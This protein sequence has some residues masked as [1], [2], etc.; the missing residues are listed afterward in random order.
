MTAGNASA[1]GALLKQYRM[2]AGLTQE[3]LAERA[4]LS[5][6]GLLYL[7][8]GTRRPYPDT[9]RRLEEA[10]ALSPEQ[11]DALA[12]AAR[13]AHSG[14]E[15]AAPAAPLILAPIPSA[16]TPL[17]GRVREVMEVTTL[18][19]EPEMRLVTL[20]GPG[21]I[22]KTRL[23]LAVATALA[24]DSGNEV[25]FA[26]LAA[27]T[28]PELVLPAITAALG[29]KV[30]TSELPME[31]VRVALRDR[32]LLLILDNFEQI[33]AAAPEIADLLAACPGITL[34]VTSRATL[35]LRGEHEFAV[36]PMHLPEA[37]HAATADALGEYEAI[38]LFVDRARAITPDFRL[39]EANARAVAEIC[40]RLDGLPLA[41]ELAAARIR[42]LTPIALLTRLAKSLTV[43]T[44]GARDLPARQQTL[45]D[46]IRWSYDLLNLDERAL[47]RR[48]AVFANG[49]TLEAI[50][51][52]CNSAGDLAIDLLDGLE[53]LLS[54]SLLY[55]GEGRD[56]DARFHMLQTIREFGI[57]QL[58][59]LGEAEMLRERHAVYF[60]AVA[61]EGSVELRGAR[62]DFWFGRLE[63][64]HD[65]LRAVLDWSLAQRPGELPLRLANALGLFWQ[66]HGYND[67][68]LRWLEASLAAGQ[69]APEALRV[70]ALNRISTLLMRQGEFARARAPLEASLAMGQSAGDL[71]LVARALRNLGILAYYQGDYATARAR[72]EAALGVYQAL[73][74]GGSTGSVLNNLGIIAF[75][76]ADYVQ[77]RELYER[78]L[79]Q[80]RVQGDQSAIANAL[81]NLALIAHLLGDYAS[82]RRL[83]EEGLALR[84]HAGEKQAIAASLTNLGFVCADAGDAGAR[85]MLR[86]GLALYRRVGDR[87]GATRAQLYLELARHYQGEGTVSD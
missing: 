39:T 32:R 14:N 7:E 72:S 15:P 13:S 40:Q 2:R 85:Q 56:G 64:E 66:H 38:R 57:E 41:I 25:A 47:L 70:D 22:G 76:E 6:R 31:D 60:L 35:R 29:I 19:R 59:A 79:A 46:T 73:G 9:L 28:D 8:H 67:E 20:T 4:E 55:R 27:L 78:S 49:C 10:L 42:T 24:E 21:G 84:R 87:L 82:A 52:V 50:E 18:L 44:G 71:W 86:E 83:H 53:S 33:V 74:D 3:E 48:L 80:V 58:D 69:G 34:L 77:A 65:N 37:H 26:P 30:G 62:Q 36:P 11:R 5:V 54:Q 12:A 45:R 17:V 81:N 75:R 23:A 51:A 63:E 16:S 61:E 1:F 68:G 43:L